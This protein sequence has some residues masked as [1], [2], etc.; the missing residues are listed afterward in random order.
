MPLQQNTIRVLMSNNA[1][2]AIN[3]TNRDHLA[4]ILDD[5]ISGGGY[6]VLRKASIIDLALDSPKRKLL[7]IR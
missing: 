2:M 7:E 4:V 5:L 1:S 3:F 6:V